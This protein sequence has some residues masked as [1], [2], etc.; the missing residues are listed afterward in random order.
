M[1][2]YAACMHISP[3]M[4]WFSLIQAETNNMVDLGPLFCPLPFSYSLDLSLH[5]VSC[6]HTHT[7]KH[8]AHKCFI[9][10]QLTRPSY[11]CFFK[12]KMPCINQITLSMQTLDSLDLKLNNNKCDKN[13][14]VRFCWVAVKQKNVCMNKG[15]WLCNGALSNYI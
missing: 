7:L 3:D 10:H 15:Q 9:K 1:Y 6:T 14:F 2:S 12:I 8:Y 11:S 4:R 13:A 5:L